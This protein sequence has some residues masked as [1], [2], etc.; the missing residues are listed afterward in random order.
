MALAPAV[1][2]PI[3]GIIARLL[4]ACPEHLK[5]VVKLA[6]YTGMRQGGIW[7]NLG[8]GGVEGG[9]IPLSPQDTKTNERRLVPLNAELMAMFRAMPGGLPGTPVTCRGSPVG[10]MKRSFATAV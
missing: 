7:S 4:A 8:S 5:P 9:F 1:R 3:P 2:R 10:K 6:Y